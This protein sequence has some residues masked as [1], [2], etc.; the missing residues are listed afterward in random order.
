MAFNYEDLDFDDDR[1][2]QLMDI[3]GV[4]GPPEQR[5][6]A[7]LT[8]EDFFSGDYGAGAEYYD[9]FYEGGTYGNEELAGMYAGIPVVSGY[10]D[11]DRNFVAEQSLY[12][13]ASG[14]RDLNELGVESFEDWIAR[15]RE[16]GGAAGFQPDLTQTDEYQTMQEMQALLSGEGQTEGDMTAAET[17]AA[18]SAGFAL[19]DG[20]GDVA[21]YRAARQA[22]KTQLDE[23]TAGQQGIYGTEYEGISRRANSMQIQ[24]L[25]DSNMQMVEALGM[26]STAAAYSKMNEVSSLIANVNIQYEMKLW[27]QDQLLRQFE[28]EAMVGRRKNMQDQG[29]AVENQFLNQLRTNRRGALEAAAQG[30]NVIVETNDAYFKMHERDLDAVRTEAG[31]IYQ[32]VMVDIE[33]NQAAMERANLAYEAYMAPHIDALNEFIVM[34]QLEDQE[35]GGVDLSAG[36]ALGITGASAGA[37]V[38]MGIGGP[39]GAGIGLV[40]GGLIGF[41]GGLFS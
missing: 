24:T 34:S 1:I 35:E 37:I 22:Y 32:R 23:G 6:Y 25:I 4:A 7:T 20:T 18:L 40:I 21:G 13:Q 10:Y 11:P 19:P 30:I 27:E 12:N 28:Y 3:Y 2:K 38:G 31:L 8:G 39:I 26:K 5:E 17:Q 14:M 9:P 33:V 36:A 41:L 29:L 16:E 15:Q